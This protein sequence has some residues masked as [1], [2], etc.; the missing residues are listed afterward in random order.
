MRLRV[1]VPRVRR[2]TAEA[3]R[4]WSRERHAAS[5]GSELSNAARMICCSCA[6]RRSQGDLA[7]VQNP[8][9]RH[10]APQLLWEIIAVGE[11]FACSLKA[12]GAFLAQLDGGGGHHALI[13]QAVE[14]GAPLPRL[15]GACVS[16][17]AVSRGHVRI[18]SGGLHPGQGSCGPVRH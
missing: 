7:T 4:A 11:R 9:L 10:G 1:N 14:K 12:R 5:G 8:P 15:G 16:S 2:P 6:R 18:P 3:T 17:P 13:E